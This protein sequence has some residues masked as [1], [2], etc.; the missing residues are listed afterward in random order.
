MTDV[1]A[2]VTQYDAELGG[3]ALAAV[4]AGYGILQLFTGR[5]PDLE[6]RDPRTIRLVGSAQILVGA[7]L[8][9]ASFRLDR[10]PGWGGPAQMVALG[11]WL[12][13]IGA[14]A[15]VNIPKYWRADVDQA[16]RT[17]TDRIDAAERLRDGGPR[18]R[19]A[20]VRRLRREAGDGS[21]V[22]LADTPSADRMST[23]G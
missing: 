4:I 23:T 11:A 7:A 21:R 9:T 19:T 2:F 17:E 14:A 5:S 20:R 18:L 1:I 10:E 3:T 8:A 13:V 22:V 6:R 16:R 12:A 15:L